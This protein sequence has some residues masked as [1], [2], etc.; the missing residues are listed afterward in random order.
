MSFRLGYDASDMHRAADMLEQAV[1]VA[2]RIDK[3]ADRMAGAV[4]D[5]GHAQLAGAAEH[6]LETWGHGVEVIAEDAGGLGQALRE[7][8]V[9]Y[10]NADSASEAAL[11]RNG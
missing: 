7:A 2:R 6:F 11:R 10:E 8:V 1:E 3:D 9:S 5:C 4:S